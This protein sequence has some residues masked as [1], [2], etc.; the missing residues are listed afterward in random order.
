MH[1]LLFFQY[2]NIGTA[3]FGLNNVSFMWDEYGLWTKTLIYS[4][5]ATGCELDFYFRR[6]LFA[7]CYSG[8]QVIWP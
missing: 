8:I 3:Y 6:E 7:L 4:C 5:S 2:S 1:D